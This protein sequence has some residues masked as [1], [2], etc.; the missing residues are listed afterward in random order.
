VALPPAFYPSGPVRDLPQREKTQSS[1]SD[2]STSDNT[3]GKWRAQACVL[4]FWH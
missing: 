2:S 3:N 4:V 1:G